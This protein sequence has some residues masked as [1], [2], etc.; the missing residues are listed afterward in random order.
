M[1]KWS[2]GNSSALHVKVPG[3]DSPGV[4]RHKHGSSGFRD[5]PHSLCPAHS[6]PLESVLNHHFLTLPECK[7]D[8]RF[9]QL[10]LYTHREVEMESKSDG[11]GQ[12][13]VIT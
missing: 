9:M 4:C 1:G 11:I 13:G 8:L 7:K 6:V 2:R 10:S 5:F 3:F 12:S